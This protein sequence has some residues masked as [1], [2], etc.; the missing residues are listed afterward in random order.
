MQKPVDTGFGF[1]MLKSKP[2]LPI[3]LPAEGF[4]TPLNWPE[5][6]LCPLHRDI[7]Q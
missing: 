3:Q 4:H 1:F 7:F 2:N 6:L 5:F